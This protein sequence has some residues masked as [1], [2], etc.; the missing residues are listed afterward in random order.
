MATFLTLAL[1]FPTAI[2]STLLVFIVLYWA[3]V[4]MGAVGFDFG[5]DG[6]LEGKTGALEAK[7][8]ALEGKSGGLEAKGG[9]MEALGFGV[10]PGSVVISFIVFWAWTMSMMGAWLVSPI[11]GGL[12]P[13]WA[14]G[15]GVAIVALFTSLFLSAMTV[16]PLRPLF[17]IQSAPKRREL[18]GKTAMVSS[19]RVD[20]EF[21]TATMED[22]GSGLILNVFCGKENTLKKGDQVLLLQYDE[23]RQAYEVEP[24]EWLLPEELQQLKE[25]RTA[26]AVARA[27]A[28]Q[29]VGR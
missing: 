27:H 2:F 11:A 12:M 9:M 5:A 28:Q 14:V 8:G 10:V 24:V 25:P 4:L 13:M 3:L 17:E 29:R 23:S 18:L 26:E 21:G 7:A 19:G 1:S 15:S 6:A 16:K 20:A 22:G